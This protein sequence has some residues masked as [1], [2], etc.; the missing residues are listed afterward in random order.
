MWTKVKLPLITYFS[1]FLTALVRYNLC[2]ILF[3]YLEY[4]IQWFICK[5]D[6]QCKFDAW[7]RETQSWCSGTTQ[8]EVG[9]GFRIRGHVYTLY[10]HSTICQLYLNKTE[11]KKDVEFLLKVIKMF[12][13]WLW[14]WLH[15][16]VNSL[17]ATEFFKLSN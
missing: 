7:S 9:G 6:D 10:L 15:I 8:R 2:L 17:K 16:S 1:L 5:I 12:W 11:K 3:T 14:W 13:N 4:K